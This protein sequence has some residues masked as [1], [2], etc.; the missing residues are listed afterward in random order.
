MQQ[1][2][3]DE[4]ARATV[5]SSPLFCALAWSMRRLSGSSAC[6]RKS[7]TPLLLLCCALLCALP[8]LPL[9][10]APNQLAMRPMTPCNAAQHLEP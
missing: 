10:D 6:A 5:W 3:L 2:Q 8:F 7:G 4:Q 9:V 1:M